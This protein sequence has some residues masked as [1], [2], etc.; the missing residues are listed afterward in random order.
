MSVFEKD[1][2]LDIIRFYTYF[3][4]P[5]T[6]QYDSKLLEMNFS[7]SLLKANHLKFYVYSD[8]P[9]LRKS[10]FLKKFGRYSEGIK[11]DDTEFNM[12][13]SFLKKRGKGLIMKDYKSTFEQMNLSNEPSTMQRENWKLQDKTIIKALRKGYLKYRLLKNSVQL[14]AFNSKKI[15]RLRSA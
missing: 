7:N 2:S 14:I 5:Y 10:T 1:K 6:Q 13:L 4:Y 8:H 12:C 15:S 3:K 9:H 11:G